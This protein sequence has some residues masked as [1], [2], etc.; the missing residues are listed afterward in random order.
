MKGK[1]D[2]GEWKDMAQTIGDLLEKGSMVGWIVG[3]IAS[4]AM[5][6]VWSVLILSAFVW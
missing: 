4:I 5:L 3:S 6:L 2:E 1:E